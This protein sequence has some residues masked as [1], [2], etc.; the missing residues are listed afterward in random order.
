MRR[1]TG[2]SIHAINALGRLVAADSHRRRKQA[3]M[4]AFA[5]RLAE[6]GCVSRAGAETGISAK[7]AENYFTEI[8]R[9]L[10]PQAYD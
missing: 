4:A 9:D 7:T 6:H 5:D 8:R 3:R 10:G 2:A 1:R